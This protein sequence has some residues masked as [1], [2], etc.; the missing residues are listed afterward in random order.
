MFPSLNI[1]LTLSHF[2]VRMRMHKAV[3]GES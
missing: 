2:A 1:D 3:V